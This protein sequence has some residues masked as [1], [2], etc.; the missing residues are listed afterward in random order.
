MKNRTIIAVICIVLA[1]VMV[2][3][4]SPLVNKLTTDS[5]DVVRLSKN[6][7]RGTQITSEHLEMVSVKRDTVPGGI[8]TDPN[9]IIGK[10]AATDLFAG[11]Y[12]TNG[13]IAG[14]ANSADDVFADMNGKVAISVPLGSFA[15]HLS[16][17][18]QNG[19]IIRFYVRNTDL[20]ASTFVPGALQWVKVVTTTTGG[21]IDQNEIVE[22]EDGTYEMPATATILVNETQARI[23]AEYAA[24]SEIHLA[25]IYRGTAEKAQEYLKLQDDYFEKLAAGEIEDSTPTYDNTDTGNRPGSGDTIWDEIGDILDDPGS[26]RDEQTSGSDQNQPS[27]DKGTIYD[28]VHDILDDPRNHN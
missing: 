17:K 2:F 16:G 19:D 20:S 23:L 5:M 27:N 13:K 4:V 1:I 14:E 8:I 21:G 25:L 22:N 12:L 15:G 10:Y 28:D 9:L 11:D 26:V 7:T 24:T 3:V 6:L 18:L